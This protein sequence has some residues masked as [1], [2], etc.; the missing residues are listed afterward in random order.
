M[1]SFNLKEQE[2]NIDNKI[3]VALERI[4][5]AFKV[6][7]WKESK[8]NS[9]SPIQIQVLI[10]LLFHSEE[11]CKVSYLADEFNLTKATISDSIRVLHNKEL[12]FKAY[13]ETDSRSYTI[14]LSTKGRGI[15]K[16]SAY[17]TTSIEK[18]IQQFSE[19]QKEVV[20]SSL[21]QM[22]KSL[23]TSG[24]ITLQRMCFSCT[25]YKLQ[26]NQHFCTLLQSNLQDSELRVDCEDHALKVS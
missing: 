12:I 24:V 11:K 18:P 5:E 7:L 15:A 14:Q 3:V 10:F 25:N 2:N 22:I 13:N 23:N 21:L 19:E 9:L 16:K 26:N 1:S 20:F 17:F 8:E 4:S 6:L